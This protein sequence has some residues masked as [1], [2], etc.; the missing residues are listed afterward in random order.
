MSSDDGY[1]P[2]PTSFPLK[3]LLSN[4]IF[5]TYIVSFRLYLQGVDQM[6]LAPD[7]DWFPSPWITYA[8]WDITIVI[9]DPHNYKCCQ[10]YHVL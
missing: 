3:A 1:M 9:G 10:Y 6:Q 8:A 4:I 5:V 7:E 2:P